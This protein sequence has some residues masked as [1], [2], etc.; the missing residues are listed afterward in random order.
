MSLR[1]ATERSAPISEPTPKTS[2]ST[3]RARAKR[4]LPAFVVEAVRDC[5]G[6]PPQ[7]VMTYL[8][9]RTARWFR[10]RSDRRKLRRAPRSLLF[11]CHGNV[12]R[13]P[14]AAE[15]FRVRLGAASP[16][17]AV[18]SAGT[19]T[20]NG[21]LADPRAV[22][23]AVKLGISLASHRSQML[24]RLMVD[25]A[26][27]ICVMDHRNEAEVVARFPGASR[28]TILLGG[29]D[30]KSRLG[31]SIPDPYTLDADA[32]SAIYERVAT[33]VDA[34]VAMLKAR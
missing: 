9:L 32:V 11:V 28:K 29:V 34:L 14:V 25:R 33:A 12:M 31:P 20:T 1:R 3:L 26:E 22:A 4:A 13:S 21:R 15:L 24:T 17:F 23:E 10:F 5:N 19:W 8:R 18:T 2:Q 6:M 16:E 30:K 27:L 7:M